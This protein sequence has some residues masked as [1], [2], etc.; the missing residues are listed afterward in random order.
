M[1]FRSM[2]DQYLR[3][4]LFSAAISFLLQALTG[5]LLM[6]TY[7]PSARPA[8][9]ES[10]KPVVMLEITKTLRDKPTK[11]TYTAGTTLFA[12]YDTA[13]H[14][15]ILA[16]DTLRSVSRIITHPLTKQALMPS[17]AYLSV[18][19][20]ITRS[21]DFGWLVRGV[22]RTS[23]QCVIAFLL[24]W[25]VANICLKKYA[26][27]PLQYWFAA[28]GIFTISLAS[29]LT[30]YILPF[31]VRSVTALEI[32]TSR[33]N[34]LT[35]VRVYALHVAVL[36]ILVAICWLFFRPKTASSPSGSLTK[37]LSLELGIITCL[38]VWV[39]IMG[40]SLF[41]PAQGL[42]SLPA[43][44]TKPSIHA[45]DALPAWYLYP[46]FLLL[47]MLPISIVTTL[48]AFGMLLVALL[49]LAK[50]L[51]KIVQL[52]IHGGASILALAWF[53][54]ALAG[55]WATTSFANTPLTDEIVEVMTVSSILTL[56]L[57]V[58]LVLLKR[59]FYQ[60]SSTEQS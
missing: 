45:P 19:Q 42:A 7:E 53:I 12:E 3:V 34:A 49:P 36:P 40:A 17:A 5:V 43:D 54:A 39:C 50:F 52:L 41:P 37:S 55:M 38:I 48:L 16:L 10:G 44:L 20:A 30:G 15:P 2:L 26:A 29:G 35:L 9:S 24:V 47:Q 25:L 60:P 11:T 23:A 27:I 56:V 46:I 51:P 31:D 32:L 58:S 18:Q 57:L 59:S 14:A 4:A 1:Q 21:A 13:Q 33:I 6:T 22:H 8:M 28:C